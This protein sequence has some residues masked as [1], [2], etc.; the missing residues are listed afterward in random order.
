MKKPDYLGILDE[1]EDKE[2]TDTGK[3]SLGH[4]GDLE[5]PQAGPGHAQ[6]HGDSDAG[7]A[8]P[9]GSNDDDPTVTPGEHQG[10]GDGP[11]HN[12]TQDDTDQE[13]GGKLHDLV[14]TLSDD[15]KATLLKLLR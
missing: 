6:D 11:S 13:A 10:K 3:R 12:E 5:D 7:P 1:V 2:M 15:D 14:K 4:L 8:D 9:D